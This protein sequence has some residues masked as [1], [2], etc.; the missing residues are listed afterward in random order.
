V[1]ADVLPVVVATANVLPVVVELRVLAI[2]LGVAAIPGWALLVA[3]PAWRRLP[4]LQ[5]WA[6]AL[7]LGVAFWP[8]LFTVA[9]AVPGAPPLGREALLGV[10]LVAALAAAAGLR[11][12]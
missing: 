7:S 12:A 5:A 9:G 2:T 6:M 4:T 1:T 3:A 10:L 11:R 8:V